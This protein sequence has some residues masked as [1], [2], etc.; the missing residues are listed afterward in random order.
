[1]KTS[2]LITL[3]GIF[4]VVAVVVYTRFIPKNPSYHNDRQETEKLNQIKEL[5]VT[6]KD[7]FPNEKIAKESRL[8]LCQLTA[9]STEDQSKAVEAIQSLVED[10]KAEVKYQCSDSFFDTTQDKLVE[11]RSETYT[12]GSN[13]FQVNPKT[14]HVIQINFK[15][16]LGQQKKINRTQ[17][18]ATIKEFIASHVNS[19]GSIDLTKYKLDIGSKGNNQSSNYF[20]TWQGETTKVKL[21]P[22][23]ETCSKDMAKNVPSIYYKEDGIPC[24]MN[25][26]TNVTPV[27]QVAIN[28]QGQILNYSNTFEGEIGR[29]I[30]F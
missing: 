26:E 19:L 11:A 16:P 22:P 25:Y 20:F 12:V 8:K 15:E 24:Y 23:S 27:I 4:I 5:A 1:M 9:R 13:T 3:F 28:D 2:K 14:N 6:Y 17:A 7:G 10:S 29:E 18:E 21:D 30:T